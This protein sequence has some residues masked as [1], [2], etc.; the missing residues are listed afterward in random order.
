L[1]FFQEG[2][3]CN[4]GDDIDGFTG[5]AKTITLNIILSKKNNALTLYRKGLAR[6]YVPD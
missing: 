3:T 4:D 2:E 6:V 5:K 1:I